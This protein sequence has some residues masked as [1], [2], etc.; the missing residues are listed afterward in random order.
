MEKRGNNIFKNQYNT[1][2]TWPKNAP[3]CHIYNFIIKQKSQLKYKQIV[4]KYN[5]VVICH[6]QIAHSKNDSQYVLIHSS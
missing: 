2:K 5:E 6:N 4:F 1:Y 3:K